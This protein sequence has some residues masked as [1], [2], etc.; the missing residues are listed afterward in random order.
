VIIKN[1]GGAGNRTRVRRP[2]APSFYARSPRFKSR[3][4]V[5]RGPGP[6]RP[7]RLK[8]SLKAPTSR[9]LQASP[10]YLTPDTG[11]TG[12]SRAS[13]AVLCGQSVLVRVGACFVP[14]GFTGKR[15]PGAPPGASTVSVETIRPQ[16]FYIII[17]FGRKI[18]I[19]SKILFSQEKLNELFNFSQ[20]FFFLYC[21]STIRVF[22]FSSFFI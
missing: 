9:G 8:I 15:E 5:P 13:V 16:P 7:A 6:R 2:S 12:Q 18:Y 10:V 20:N 4:L 11:S 1:G 14:A 22:A 19:F 17:I 3:L 21:P